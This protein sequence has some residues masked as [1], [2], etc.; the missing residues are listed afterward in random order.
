MMSLLLLTAWLAAGCGVA[1]VIGRSSDL[2][3]THEGR[4]MALR[5]GSKNPDAAAAGHINTWGR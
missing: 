5:A 4:K 3:K 1:L 2:G